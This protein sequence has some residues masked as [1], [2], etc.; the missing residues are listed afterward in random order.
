MLS[1]MSMDPINIC[2]CNQLS[3]LNID[4]HGHMHFCVFFMFFCS[5]LTKTELVHGR[6]VLKVYCRTIKIVE[7]KS[8][9]LVQMIMM[10]SKA[11]LRR[12]KVS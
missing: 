5:E 7:K 11:I 8:E 4:N 1:I 10:S 2:I 3:E 6:N 12:R 9:N